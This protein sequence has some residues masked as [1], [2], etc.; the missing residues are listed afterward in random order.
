MTRIL[1]VEDNEMNSDMLS[2]RLGKRGF[3]VEIVTNGE[4]CQARVEA[5]RPALVLM[6]LGLPGID[7]IETTSRLKSDPATREIPVIALSAHTSDADVRRSMEAGCSDF[8]C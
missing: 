1:L 7:G 8:D 3:E 5:F 2:R 4:S 6:D